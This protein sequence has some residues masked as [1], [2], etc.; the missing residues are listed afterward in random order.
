MERRYL[1]VALFAFGLML[2]GSTQTYEHTFGQSGNS[3]IVETRDLTSYIQS[4]PQ[5]ALERLAG[6][7]AANPSLGCSVSGVSMTTTIAMSPGGDYAFSSDYGIPFVTTTLT[8]SRIPSDQFDS[9]LNRALVA[10][11]LT[12]SGSSAKPL[13]LRD[14]DANARLASAWKSVGMTKTYTVVMPNGYS[15]TYDV[16]ALLEDSRPV[17]LVTQDLNFGFLVVA[18]GVLVLGAFAAS[19]FMDKRKKRK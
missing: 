3:L 11:D 8:V 18:L 14:A 17:T 19:F 13:D 10:A 1:L 4:Y 16:I 12:A 9:A 5:G 15:K 7:C 6:A 2:T